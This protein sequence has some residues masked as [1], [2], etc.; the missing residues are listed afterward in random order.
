MPVVEESGRSRGRVFDVCAERKGDRYLV[1]ALVVG[2][3][4]LIQ[5]LGIRPS[6]RGA[7]DD[8]DEIPWEQVLRVGKDRIVIRKQAKR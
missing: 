5:R 4:G 1:T 7:N 3:H 8:R 6:G 2:Q